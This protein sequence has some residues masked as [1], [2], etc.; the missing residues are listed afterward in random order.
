MLKIQLLKIP[1]ACLFVEIQRLAGI[2]SGFCAVLDRCA[3]TAHCTGCR[4]VRIRPVS[5]SKGVMNI[6]VWRGDI[7]DYNIFFDIKFFNNPP[8]IQGMLSIFL[9][10][11][12]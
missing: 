8:E 4:R 1:V 12:E 9:Q 5:D 6:Q 3:G 11:H 10:M 2:L 7:L